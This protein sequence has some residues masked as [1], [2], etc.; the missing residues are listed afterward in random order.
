MQNTPKWKISREMNTKDWHGEHGRPIS[1]NH[2]IVLIAAVLSI[3]APALA[4]QGGTGRPWDPYQIANAEQLLRIASDIELMTKSFVLVNDIDLDPNSPHGRIFDTAVITHIVEAETDK[5]LGSALRQVGDRHFAVFQGTFFGNSHAIRNMVI[6]ASDT[7]CVGLFA[8]IAE[9]AI[10]S[11]LRIE[12]ARVKGRMH[13]GL[14]AGINAGTVSYCA[15]TG[16]VAADSRAGGM[17]GTNRGELICCGVD[18]SVTG[19]YMLGGLVGHA[20]AKSSIMHCRVKAQVVGQRNVGGLVGQMLPGT[21]MGCFASGTVTSDADAG[22]LVGAGPFGGAVLK[23]YS[24]VDV[25]GAVIGGLIGI[26]QRTNITNSHA[27]GV[28]AQIASAGPANNAALGGIVGHWRAGSGSIISS[29][30]HTDT[31]PADVAIGTSAPN[32]AVNLLSTCGHAPA[33]EESKGSPLR[34]AAPK[35]KTIDLTHT[36][37]KLTTAGLLKNPLIA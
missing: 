1:I 12:N 30:W 35:D 16:S 3:S 22:G 8:Y 2:L 10:V 17:I 5:V 11:D 4:F 33:C 14:L 29:S 9:D 23:C 18:T 34:G 25:K 32:A 20:I 13:V 27:F 7:L 24:A 21:L 15:V 6:D 28:L 36:I 31:A 19:K 37:S 26:A